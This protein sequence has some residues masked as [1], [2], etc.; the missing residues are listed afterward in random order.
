M[1]RLLNDSIS[2]PLHDPMFTPQKPDSCLSVYCA[3]GELRQR[4]KT[5]H[6]YLSNIV[7]NSG[8]MYI[9]ASSQ[10][11]LCRLRRL[12]RDDNSLLRGSFW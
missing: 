8:V 9:Y 7:G 2:L 12:I 1:T 6:F 10:I 4:L 5:V 11:S 3:L